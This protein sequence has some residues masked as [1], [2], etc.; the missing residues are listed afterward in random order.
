MTLSP[1]ARWNLRNQDVV[2]AAAKKLE[3]RNLLVVADELQRRGGYCVFEGCAETDIE[4]HHR[5]PATKNLNIGTSV[6]THGVQRLLAELALCDPYCR[7]HH[8]VVDGRLERAREH[9]D[10]NYKPRTSAKPGSKLTE[11][12][13]R[14]IRTRKRCGESN[15]TVAELFG[16]GPS[17]VSNIANRKVWAWLSD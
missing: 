10:Y 8:M 6:R 7:L 15:R 14:E 11:E 1:Q 9:R 17:A 4:W 3:A 5:D 13:V 16:I 2:K 12:D